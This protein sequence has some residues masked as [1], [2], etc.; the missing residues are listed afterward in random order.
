MRFADAE[1]IR[2]QVSSPHPKLVVL[3]RSGHVLPVDLERERVARE[4]ADFLCSLEEQVAV[5][6]PG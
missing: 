2:G 5:D 6:V 1:R 4:V 3:E